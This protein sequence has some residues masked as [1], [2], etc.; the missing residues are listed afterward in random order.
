MICQFRGCFFLVVYVRDVE[1]FSF[2]VQLLIHHRK[3][4]EWF[5]LV[6]KKFIVLK[7]SSKK[8]R[9]FYFFW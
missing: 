7:F 4:F 5:R 3:L 8:F 9:K 6:L 1:M 2:Y